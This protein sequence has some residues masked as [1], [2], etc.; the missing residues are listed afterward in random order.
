LVGQADPRIADLVSE[1]ILVGDEETSA[2]PAESAGFGLD[3]M[4][5]G[6]DRQK[7]QSTSG[8]HRSAVLAG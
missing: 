2:Y 4:A 7:C 1:A 6:I 8:P 3:E 5:E